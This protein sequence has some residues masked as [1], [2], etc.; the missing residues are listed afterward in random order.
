MSE[1]TKIAKKLHPV[2]RSQPSAP[3]VKVPTRPPLTTPIDQVQLSSELLEPEARSGSDFSWL[4]EPEAQTRATRRPPDSLASP[5]TKSRRRPS[6][7]GPDPG[8]T[9][10]EA[11]ELARDLKREFDRRQSKLAP[12]NTTMKS[13]VVKSKVGKSKTLNNKAPVGNRVKMNSVKA[14]PQTRKTL[15]KSAPANLKRLNKY[16]SGV[17][18]AH[19]TVESVNHFRQGHWKTGAVE[20]ASAGVLVAE[21]SPLHP[22]IPGYGGAAVDTLRAVHHYQGNDPVRAV[23]SGMEAVASLGTLSPVTAPASAA[24]SVTRFAASTVSVNG[25]TADDCATRI[26]DG[27]VN[28]DV[29][30]RSMSQESRMNALG[31]SVLG[32]D[33]RH[34]PDYLRRHRREAAEGVVA[35]RTRLNQV[36]DAATRARIRERLRLVESLRESRN[37]R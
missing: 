11:Q 34:L 31:D 24:Y 1:S 23:E 32:L 21:R 22:K 33:S 9:D 8:I 36:H 30:H 19:H 2:R 14:K 13:K 12:S 4:K 15:F 28:Q 16:Q 7:P 25:V 18:V 35:L 17:S 37:S 26:L 6:G 3:A 29:N 10:R 5:P 20:A 27:Y